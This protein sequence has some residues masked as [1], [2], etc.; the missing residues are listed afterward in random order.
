MRKYGVINPLE[1]YN[2]APEF[3]EKRRARSF[4]SK[5]GI[6][7]LTEMG[8]P[9]VDQEFGVFVGKKTYV[10]DGISADRKTIYEFYG[11]WWHGNPSLYAPDLFNVKTKTTMGKLYHRTLEREKKLRRAGYDVISIWE[12]D[13]RNLRKQRKQEIRAK[14]EI[15]N[16][17]CPDK[18]AA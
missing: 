4:R 2:V 9:E 18:V 11:D 14:Q 8:I 6:D 15:H 5:I 13:Y 7:W 3:A 12:A 1:M 10:V 17:L 16:P